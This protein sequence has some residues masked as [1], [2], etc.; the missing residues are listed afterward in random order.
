VQLGG[1]EPG[2]IEP[3]RV[4]DAAYRVA[5]GRDRPLLLRLIGDI[6]GEARPIRLFPA[7]PLRPGDPSLAAIPVIVVSAMGD[8][9]SV[10]KVLKTQ[11]C[12]PKPIHLDALLDAVEE[13]C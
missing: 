11:G 4:L 9:F 5:H 8:V 7:F 3:P 6:F 1:G 12:L 13:N 2:R 10:A